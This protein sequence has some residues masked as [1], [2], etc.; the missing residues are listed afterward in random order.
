M[1]TVGPRCMTACIAIQ[2]PMSAAT[3]GTI[4]TSGNG[5]RRRGKAMASGISCNGGIS[6]IVVILRVPNQARIESLEASM[7]N[8]T[9]AP[10]AMAPG[11]ALMVA[12]ERSCT[13]AES[14][15]MT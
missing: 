9:T 12:R 2:P 13:K 5:A 1:V 6:G 10:K 4:Q 3:M 7:V 11:P 8:T 15:V 14:I